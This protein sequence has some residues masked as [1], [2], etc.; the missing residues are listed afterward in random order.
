MLFAELSVVASSPQKPQSSHMHYPGQHCNIQCIAQLLLD[1][2]ACICHEF[3]LWPQWV[4]GWADIFRRKCLYSEESSSTIKFNGE[5]PSFRC[6][7]E[8][9]LIKCIKPS[10]WNALLQCL[11]FCHNVSAQNKCLLGNYS[12]Y[13]KC[14]KSTHA[15]AK[16][17][18]NIVS[19]KWNECV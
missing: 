1:E 10:I 2:S 16:Q 17:I 18:S 12:T 15:H 14:T 19:H 4:N 8:V 7:V 13:K 5:G 3:V 11:L 9:P 6:T